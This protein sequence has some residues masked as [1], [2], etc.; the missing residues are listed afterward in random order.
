ML[1]YKIQVLIIFFSIYVY[2][3]LLSILVVII[4]NYIFKIIEI[5]RILFYYTMNVNSRVDVLYLFGF[6]SKIEKKIFF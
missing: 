5:N 3:Y 2:I 4:N 1:Q 6:Y